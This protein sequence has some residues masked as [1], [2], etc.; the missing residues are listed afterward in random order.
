MT[1]PNIDS[2]TDQRIRRAIANL[3][4]EQ[5]IAIEN[6]G[7][8]VVTSEPYYSKVRISATTVTVAAGPPIVATM[9]FPVQQ[10]TCFDYAKNDP[11]TGAGYP[12]TFTATECDTNLLSKGETNGAQFVFIDGFTVFATTRSDPE[13]IRQLSMDM[14]LSASLEGRKGMFRLGNPVMHGGGGG[15][16]GGGVSD[17]LTPNLRDRQAVH[18]GFVNNGFPS[19][20]DWHRFPDCILW[21]PKGKAD[22]TWQVMLELQRAHTIVSTGHAAD[23][24]NGVQAFVP[25]A[26]QTAESDVAG[27]FVE[28]MVM[29]RSIQLGPK[30]RNR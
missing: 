24:A 9:T 7:E 27:T 4:R 28:F 23:A 30:G 16:F 26:A 13:L 21:G 19:V 22:S 18:N 20:Q 5:Q 11:M 15:W 2:I 25:P 17:V 3:P 10:R 6:S 8:L 1:T 14:Y 12:S 29:L